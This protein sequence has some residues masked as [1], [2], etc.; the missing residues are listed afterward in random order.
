MIRAP[1][2]SRP[3]HDPF[4]GPTALLWDFGSKWTALGWAEGTTPKAT[5]WN[6]AGLV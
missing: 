5:D 1:I 6:C 3:S 2:S 4:D